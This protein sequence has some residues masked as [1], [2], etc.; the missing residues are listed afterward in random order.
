MESA[1]RVK[2]LRACLRCSNAVNHWIGASSKGWASVC[3]S[4]VV[5]PKCTTEQLAHEVMGLA[6]VVSSPFPYLPHIPNNWRGGL[7]A[8]D[9][10]KIFARC[11][12]I[13]GH[14]LPNV[15]DVANCLP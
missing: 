4:H 14:E 6:K 1:S 11:L 10:A 5:S 2:Q 7:D 3:I 12:T 8:P 13:E 15:L 9:R